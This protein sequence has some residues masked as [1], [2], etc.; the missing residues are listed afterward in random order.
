MSTKNNMDF[1]QIK[2]DIT[3]FLWK[4]YDVKTNDVGGVSDPDV[5]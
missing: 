5:L 4:C 3:L 2:Y 1:K